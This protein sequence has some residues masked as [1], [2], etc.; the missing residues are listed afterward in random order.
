MTNEPAEPIPDGIIATAKQAWGDLFKWKQRVVVTN[1]FGET[2][3]EWQSPE[4]LQNPVSLLL[5]LSAKD[6]L[7][8]S[9]GFCAWTADA[10]DFHALSI[11]TKKLADYYDRSKTDI[12]TAIT[13]TLLLRSVGAAAFGLA[14]DKFGRKWPMVINMIVLG[15]LQIAT[16]Y[17]GTFQQFLAVRSLFGLFMGGV[18]GNA[19]AMALEHC[20]VNARGLMSGIL[21]QGYSLGYVLAAC[22]NLGVGGATESWKTIFWIAAGISIGVGLVRVLFPESKQFLEAKKA[23]KKSTDLGSFMGETKRM[24]GQEWKMCIYCVILMTWFNYYSHTSQDSYTTFM[25]TQK[26]MNNSQASRA[27]ILMKTGA[28][29]GGTIIGYLSQ[30]FGRRRAIICAALVSGCLI[31]AWILPQGER[32][33]S[34]T[35]FFIQFFIQGAWGV[36]PIHLN[37][38]SPPAF[39][40][41]F[42]GMTYQLGNMIS[43]PS[44]QIVNAVAEATMITNPSGHR[45]PAYGPTMGVATAIIALG[46]AVTTAFGPEKRGRKFETAVAGVE[47][48]TQKEIDLEEG[49]DDQKASDE[50]IEKAEKI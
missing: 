30:F 4:P 27:S 33:L 19:I 40:S 35:G 5:Q 8:F 28:C 1:E 41:S 26:E 46:I 22:A 36:I 29:V 38:L 10:F 25:L 24:L 3:A 31:P 32:S 2:H 15:V 39:R 20:P 14:G 12:T 44:A 34:A 21:Q 43:S 9:V 45:V 11:Q 49:F 47:Q 13:L 23:G 6:W 7:F 37:E 48:R 17:S 50:R 18:Y 42:P 16:I